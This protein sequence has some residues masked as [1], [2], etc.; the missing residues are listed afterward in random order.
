M[1]YHDLG[2]C[3]EPRLYPPGLPLPEYYVALPVAAANPLSVWGEA[4]LAGV[5]SDGVAGEPLIPCLTEVIRT[6][7]QDLVVH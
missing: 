6:V 1:C 3:L 4:D 5:P 2:M 7:D